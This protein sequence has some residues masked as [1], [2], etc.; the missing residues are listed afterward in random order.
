MSDLD[1][2]LQH[3]RLPCPTLSPGVC[4]NSCPLS[5]WCHW[6]ISPCAPTPTLPSVFPSIRV[7]FSESAFASGGQSIG[8]SATV[9]PMNIQNWFPLGLTGLISLQSKGLSRVFSSTTIWKASI[10]HPSAFFMAH[11]SHPYM[12]TGKTI[13]LTIWFFVSKVISL[14]FNMLS[15]FVIVFLPRSTHFLNFV[16]IVP[17][18]NDFG[19]QENK[20]CY[21]F[22]FF[23]FCLPW[24]DGT[25]CHDLS[26]PNVEFQASF[27][28][29][30]YHPYWEALWFF[31]TFCH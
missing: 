21:C 7:F 20:I 13:A 17:I 31:F 14:L 26:F 12:T 19:A 3:T 1:C 18:H 6:S 22:H 2:G 4:S 11:I 24:S 30:L 8:A 10:L 27:L 16:A 15:R 28:T 25:G 29:L 9:L 5:Q 23:L